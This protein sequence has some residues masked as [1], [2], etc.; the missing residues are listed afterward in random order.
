MYTICTIY[1]MVDKTGGW[2]NK[3]SPMQKESYNSRAVR[4][5]LKRNN[6]SRTNRIQ[7]V[8]SRITIIVCIKYLCVYI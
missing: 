8:N 5:C 6:E 3:S 4:R 7:T 1:T 2:K